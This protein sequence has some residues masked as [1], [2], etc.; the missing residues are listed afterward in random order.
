MGDR[1]VVM[2][3]GRIQQV[4]TPLG[5]YERPATLFV[6]GFIGSPA[7]N[8]IEG[9]ITRDHGLVFQAP[10]RAFSLSVPDVAA[11]GLAAFVDRQVL[12]GIRPE[13][14]AL[15]ESAALPAATARVPMKLTAVEPL[16]SETL[17]YGTTAGQEFTARIAPRSI[18]AEGAALELVVDTSRL[19]FFDPASGA[20]VGG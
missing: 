6:A 3:Q 18:P 11:G 4:D 9:R 17:L 20:R 15:P 14:L 7:M 5:L 8:L 12:A 13:D 16:G 1:I 19:H 10:D 2:N